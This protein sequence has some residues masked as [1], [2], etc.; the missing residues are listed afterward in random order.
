[1]EPEGAEGVERR[2]AGDGGAGR[3]MS[4]QDEARGMREPVG[5]VRT[6]AHGGAEGG[7]SPGRADRLMGRGGLTGS[8][9]AGEPGG[10]LLTGRSWRPEE[11]R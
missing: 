11:L 9:A 2:S 8:A 7:R 5:T 4:D 1:M 3:M 10:I 6:M